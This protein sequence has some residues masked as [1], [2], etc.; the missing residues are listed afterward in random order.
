LFCFPYAGGGASAFRTLAFALPADI[1]VCPV[2]LPG[3]E[4]RMTAARFVRVRQLVPALAQ[5]LQPYLDQPFAFFGYS[6]GALI[7]FELARQLRR[8]GNHHLVQMFVSAYRA[9]QLPDPHPPLHQLS[10]PL[11]ID[12]LRCMNG[13]PEE[14]LQNPELAA[15]VLPMLRADFEL[16]ETYTYVPE[17]PFDFAIHAF[18][19]LQDRKVTREELVAWR[20]QTTSRFSLHMLPGDHFFF[21][22]ARPFLTQVM[23]QELMR[24]LGR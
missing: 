24:Q 16:C 11:L 17:A 14:V 9:P 1:E 18:G 22:S 3:R 12:E 2:Q 20:E 10:D 21:H 5:A 13:T 15:I 6:M 4:N 23:S 8:E 19:G 7:S